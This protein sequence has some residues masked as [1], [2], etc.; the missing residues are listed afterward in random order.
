[1]PEPGILQNPFKQ[2]EQSNPALA[3]KYMKIWEQALQYL[4]SEL[5]E[6]TI[7]TW[8]KEVRL[9]NYDDSTAVLFVE[10]KFQRDV[11]VS[12]YQTQIQKALS[13]VLNKPVALHFLKDKD[14]LFEGFPPPSAAQ[15]ARAPEDGGA[16]SQKSNFDYDYTSRWQ[17]PPQIRITRFSFTAGRG[18]ARPICSTRS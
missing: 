16:F 12:R 17:T 14:K 6:I 11:V 9:V 8:L 3:A 15:E 2:L 7:N 5:T 1:M 18:W 4:H 10:N 13:F